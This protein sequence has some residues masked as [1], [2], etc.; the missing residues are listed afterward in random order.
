MSTSETR[1]RRF[2]LVVGLLAGA[3]STLIVLPFLNWILVAVFLAYV[4]RPLDRRLSRRLLRGLSTGISITIG[5]F[6][7]ILPE[8]VV[9]GVAA[10]QTR[11]LLVN[12]DLTFITQVDDVIGSRFG[13]QIDVTAFQEAL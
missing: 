7:I 11:R 8:I 1:S 6:A 9:L 10:N 2:L 12:F 13:V 3:V 5:L 4:L